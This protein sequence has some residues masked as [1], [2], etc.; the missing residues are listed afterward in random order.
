MS[1]KSPKSDISDIYNILIGGFSHPLLQTI[2]SHIPQNFFRSVVLLTTDMLQT[3]ADYLSLR[4]QNLDLLILDLSQLWSK[5]G[6]LVKSFK[7]VY[8]DLSILV[9]DNYTDSV[10]VNEYLRKGASGYLPINDIEAELP[11]AL[12]E[13][14][15]GKTY[16]GKEVK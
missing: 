12:S 8:P 4:C 10:L 2:S 13:I 3:H 16:I 9:L 5:G 15:S 6:E 14:F 7:E 11:P 1:K